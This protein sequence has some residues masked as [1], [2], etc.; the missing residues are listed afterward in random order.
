MSIANSV[1]LSAVIIAISLLFSPLFSNNRYS[2]TTVSGGI[3]FNDTQKGKAYLSNGLLIDYKNLDNIIISKVHSLRDLI[4]ES[5]RVD[6]MFESLLKGQKT[7]K[8]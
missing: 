3:I 6:D 4:D 7:G 5:R 8:N 1:F 2:I